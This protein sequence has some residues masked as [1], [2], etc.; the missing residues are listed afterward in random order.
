MTL[1]ELER[2][3]RFELALDFRLLLGKQ[4]PDH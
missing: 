4:V 1:A 3:T 2:K